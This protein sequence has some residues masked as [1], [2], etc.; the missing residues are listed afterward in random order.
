MCLEPTSILQTF[1]GQLLCY[2]F[3]LWEQGMAVSSK[4]VIIKASSLFRE[5]REKSA[6]AQYC[7]IHR[8]IKHHGLVYWMGTISRQDPQEFEAKALALMIT[9]CPMVI[10]ASRGQAFIINIDQ[11]PIPFTF[12]RQRTL[13][14]VGAHTINI[15]K[16]TC[17]T[18][19]ATLAVTFTALGRMLTP[20]L[21][22][23]GIPGGCIA[24]WDFTTYLC[25]C[26]YACQSSVWMDEVVMLQW[27]EQVLKPHVLVAPLHVVSL[28]V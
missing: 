12:N 3:E 10:G 26:I 9:F 14:L 25:G 24:T 28:L 1:E 4:L 11:S 8:L 18:K 7:S 22:F 6:V 19:R 16:L 21:V 13:E 23:K 27:V 2:I 15:C 17:D 5:F 20:V